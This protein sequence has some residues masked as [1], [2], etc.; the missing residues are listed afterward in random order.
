MPDLLPSVAQTRG[1]LANW[2][3]R[4]WGLVTRLGLSSLL[5]TAHL[6]SKPLPRVVEELTRCAAEGHWLWRRSAILS[7]E[8]PRLTRM[9]DVAAR[10][11]PWYGRCLVR[12]LLL[13][14]LLCMRGE[15]VSLC[16]GV[17]KEHAGL[18]GHAWLE[19]GAGGLAETGGSAERFV[20]VVR[21][22]SL[23]YV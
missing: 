23:R 7:Y 9:A 19:T 15:V 21:F 14:W 20:T 13:F 17:R 5:V 2:S 18:L 4:D 22:S 3:L 12:S 16:L 11:S 6:Y 8:A 10:L 1:R